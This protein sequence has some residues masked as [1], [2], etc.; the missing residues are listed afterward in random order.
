MFKNK[1]G[2]KNLY[3]LI[4]KAHL[5]YFYKKPR[6][7]K[8]ELVKHREGLLLG[9]ACEAGELYRSIVEGKNHNEICKIAQFYDYL[10]IQ[11]LGNNNF[12]IRSGIVKDEE[13][14]KEI[15]RTIVKLGEELN[16][17]VVAT[18]DVHFLDPHD[19]QYRN[20][21]MAGQGYE[22]AD[23][24]APL[25]LKTTEEML[26]EFSY[27][28]KEKAFE[29]VVENTNKI[30]DLVEEVKPIPDGVYPPFIDGAEEQLVNIT[31]ERAKKRYGDPLP[32]IVYDR[33]D[34]ELSSITKHGFSVL[35]MTAQKLV[36]DS[37]AHGYL[38]GSRGSV[39]SSFVATMSGIS[40]VNPL[41]PH[42]ICPK[43]CH[44]EF[45]TDGSYGSGF[46][47]PEKKCPKCGTLY[48]R[49][50][51][52]IPFETFLGFDGDK[53]PDIDLNFSGEYQ[54]D[55]HRYTEKLFG[56]DN[57][58][59]AGT[60]ATIADK[61]GMGFVKKYEQDKGYTLHKAGRCIGKNVL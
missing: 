18:C 15:N 51:H 53:T 32:K 3:K 55:A 31:W 11:P 41:C 23:S 47:L 7:P 54:S 1:V 46:D 20:I 10:E 57:V 40:E 50:G 14:L 45:I 58:F 34:R 48:D 5:E 28:G 30:A 61:T 49:D 44:S 37:E 38:V 26:E 39:G 8:S 52:D 25:Y 21:L 60:I 6:I 12:M 43:C 33:L 24:Q 35:Y 27:L 42:Y 19:S 4:S 13:A 9:S 29:V 17:P 22:D 2:L 59:K 16:I 36:A 56:K